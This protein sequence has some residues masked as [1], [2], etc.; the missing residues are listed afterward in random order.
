MLDLCIQSGTLL[1]TRSD[2]MNTI[3]KQIITELHLMTHYRTEQGN[4]RL[5]PR[6]TL[7]L[8]TEYK[9]HCDKFVS[10]V[11]NNPGSLARL[12]KKA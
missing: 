2:T 3:K 5:D 12:F 7:A 1:I 9:L 10:L 8:Q 4:P 11:N 6:E